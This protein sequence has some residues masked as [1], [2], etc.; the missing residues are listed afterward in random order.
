[1]TKRK[2][3]MANDGFR[4]PGMTERVAI[5]GRTGS[6]KTQQAN[7]LV[8]KA[9][10]HKMPY[11]IVDYKGDDLINSIDRI[12]EIGLN[13]AIPKSPGLYVL[14]PTGGSK[15]EDLEV[16]KWLWKLWA[17]EG[18]GLYVDEAYMLP[19]KG[20]F[21]A[22]LTQGRSKRI[23][24]IVLTQR[25]SWISRFVFSEA[26]FYSVF[27]LNDKDDRLKI[28]RFMPKTDD[29]RLPDFHSR[30]Y[31]VKRDNEFVLAPCPSAEIIAQTIDDRL[32]PK[33]RVT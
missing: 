16:E 15:D 13:E 27:H 2:R 32:T 3:K 14:R 26:D 12:K 9:P 31:D 19:D 18:A 20:A 10:F 1:M 4:L 30:W 21:Q 22:I 24:A 11:C 5:M 25:P 6:G 17:R 28:N 8:S 33:R 7:W 29:I 23:P